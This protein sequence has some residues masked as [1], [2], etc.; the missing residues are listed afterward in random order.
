VSAESLFP[1]E[2]SEPPA[3]LL[4]EALAFARDST[5]QWASTMTHMPHWYVVIPRS[6]DRRIEALADLIKLSQSRR[7]YNRRSYKFVVI[8]GFHTWITWPA[9]NKRPEAVGGWD[10]APLRDPA[11][12]LADEH[13][14]DL[15]GSLHADEVVRVR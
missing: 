4:A 7:R 15:P 11:L 6:T 12:W 2:W 10:G 9:I 1:P 3:E 5:W 13:R 14:C 8:D